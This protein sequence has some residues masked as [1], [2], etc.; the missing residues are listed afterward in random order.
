[1][2]WIVHIT[3]GKSSNRSLRKV[4]NFGLSKSALEIKLVSNIG[5]TIVFDITGLKISLISAITEFLSRHKRRYPHS[6]KSQHVSQEEK[7][8]IV[9]ST[10]NVHEKN[11][12]ETLNVANVD[13]WFNKP[14]FCCENYSFRYG[15]LSFISMVCTFRSEFTGLGYMSLS[16]SRLMKMII[17]SITIV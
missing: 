3:L 6:L 10:M 17:C 12:D 7:T 14:D 9:H 2:H 5:K 4:Q 11:P 8:F 15:F 16:H 13:L 1:M